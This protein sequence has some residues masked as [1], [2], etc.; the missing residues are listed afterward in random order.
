LNPLLRIVI[1]IGLVFATA[2]AF[3]SMWVLEFDRATSL[4]TTLVFVVPL[5]LAFV[6]MVKHRS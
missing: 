4:L 5:G 1:G 3:Y 2:Y 6:Y